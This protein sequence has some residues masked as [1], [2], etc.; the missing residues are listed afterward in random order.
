VEFLIEIEDPRQPELIA[1]LAQS[2]SYY[3]ALYPAESNH[4][5]D[6]PTLAAA[7]ATFLVA[8]T[9]GRAVGVGALLRH[10]LEFGEIKRM[11]VAP[12]MRGLKLGCKILNTLEEQAR[13]DGLPYLRLET[14]V[15]Q[16]EAIALYR[17]AGYREIPPFGN[18]KADPLSIFMEKP[19]R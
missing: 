17:S 14:G 11:Y 6:A 15:R 18:Y 3:A 16:P 1:L 13:A 8:R 5:L 7:D 2:D 9:S 4:L 12:E 10:G 19:L